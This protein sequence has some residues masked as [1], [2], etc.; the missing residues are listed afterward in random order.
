MERSD[1]PR[2]IGEESPA[3]RR[4]RR[5]PPD[6]RGDEEELPP[7]EAPARKGRDVPRVTAGPTPGVHGVRRRMKRE[8]RGFARRMRL[9]PTP[10][11]A[12]VWDMISNQQLGV[13]F[14]RQALLLGYIVDFWCPKIRLVLEVDGASHFTAEGQ[15]LDA[16]RDA[17][18]AARGIRT[19]RVTNAIVDHDPEGVR[20]AIWQEIVRLLRSDSD[21]R[22]RDS[23]PDRSSRRR[24][25]VQNPPDG[26]PT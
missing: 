19:M 15:A 16:T 17:A 14:R 9:N 22:R 5:A 4:E 10:H 7:H 23:K 21:G 25:Q 6:L 18:M 1:P 12:A 8:K 13:K 2:A 11:E 24:R 26:I 3:A 20:Q